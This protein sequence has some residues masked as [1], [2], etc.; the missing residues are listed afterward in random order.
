VDFLLS[1]LNN[2]NPNSE[3]LTKN[4]LRFYHGEKKGEDSQLE[5]VQLFMSFVIRT[6][7]KA[8]FYFL[9]NPEA[10]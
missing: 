2:I 1:C 3:F 7:S 6:N 8:D 9:F 5:L 10:I 4:H